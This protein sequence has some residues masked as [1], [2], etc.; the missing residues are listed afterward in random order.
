MR[1]YNIVSIK[2]NAN[3]IVNEGNK[4]DTVLYLKITKLTEVEVC[5]NG[6]CFSSLSFG[7][8]KKP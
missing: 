4:L 8:S 3:N 7:L 5:S 1:R 2:L 6:Q